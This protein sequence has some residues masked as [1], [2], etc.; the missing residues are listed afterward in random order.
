MLNLDDLRERVKKGE[1]SQVVMAFPDMNG[2]LLGKRLDAHFFLDF[3]VEHGTHCCLSVFNYDINMRVLSA[4]PLEIWHQGLSDFL[5]VLDWIS[6]RLASWQNKTA[7]VMCDVYD[8]KQSNRVLIPHPHPQ[9]FY[10]NKSKLKSTSGYG[11]KYHLL[12]TAPEQKY[13]EGF[14]KHLQ[15]SGIPVENSKGEVG[16]GRHELNINFSVIFSMADRHATY[17]QCLKEVVDQLGISDAVGSG[18]HIHLNSNI[19]FAQLFKHFLTGWL[20]YAPDVMVFYA[21]TINN[22]KRI[23]TGSVSPSHLAWIYDNRTTAFR[24]VDKGQ[25]T[26]I[27]CRIPGAN[28]NIY[29]ASLA[30]GLRGI[31]N[32][33]ELPP[34]FEGDVVTCYLDL[35]LHEQEQFEKHATDWE[36]H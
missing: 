17:K 28:G 30:S 5:L 13:T 23:Q 20:K 16:I 9:V 1:I 35:Y 8:D 7:T 12:Q 18:C 36:R 26:R 27:E 33:L 21:P 3:V 10:E 24:I 32:Q 4:Y 29:L 15:A 25:S 11:V 6:L 22:Y 14:R 31:T 34:I 2:R 19:N